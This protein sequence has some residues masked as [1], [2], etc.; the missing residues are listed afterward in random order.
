MYGSV[1]GEHDKEAKA[2][3][4]VYTQPRQHD[5]FSLPTVN[6]TTTIALDF[7]V[8]RCPTMAEVAPTFEAV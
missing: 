6:I 2:I 7:R 3:V 4:S 5:S 8:E 1:K